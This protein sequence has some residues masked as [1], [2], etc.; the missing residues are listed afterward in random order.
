[1]DALR[2]E[3]RQVL[4]YGHIQG[5]K[6]LRV[7]I[8]RYL[9]ASRGVECDADRIFLAS[10]TQQAISLLCQLLP[11]IRVVGMEEPG[12]DGVRTVLANHRLTIVPIP[13]EADGLSVEALRRSRADAV[14]VTPAHQFPLGG[15]LPVGKRRELLQWAEETGGLVIEGDY[16][17]E[18][19]YQ[20]QP[21]P[22]LKA[23]DALDRTIYLGT[24]SKSFMPAMRLSYMV[25]PERLAGDFRAR[26]ESYS[27][28]VSPLLQQALFLFMKD[29]HYERHVRKTRKSYQ[30]R[31]RTLLHVI[32]REMGERVGVIGQKSGLH[33]LLDVYGRESGELVNR[34]LEHGI[35]VY[36]PSRHWMNPEDCPDSYVMLGFGGLEEERISESIGWLKQAWFDNRA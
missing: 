4:G 28:S 5:Q 11:Q 18:F 25:L 7:Q 19:R 3:S 34:A 1:M 8:A 24:F 32:H 36:A 33:M 13:V 9:Q 15:V 35:R 26:L 27:Q 10:G 14:Y 12:Y 6:E 16:D 30:A 29:G 23:M 2:F 31:H 21:I 22:A 17:S 20:G